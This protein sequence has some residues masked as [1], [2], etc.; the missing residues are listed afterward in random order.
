VWLVVQ[1]PDA[2]LITPVAWAAFGDV[3]I[4]LGTAPPGTALLLTLALLCGGALALLALA[5]ALAPGVRGFGG[6]FGW[7]LAAMAAVVLGVNSTGIIVPLTWAATALLAAGAVRASGASSRSEI[8]P[9]GIGFGLGASLLLLFGLLLSAPAR[10][11]GLGVG[12]PASLMIVLAGLMLT[13]G[14]PF[15]SAL[16]EA[17]E[18]PAPLGGLIY[19]V[20]FPLLALGTLVQLHVAPLLLDNAGAVPPLHGGVTPLLGAASLLACAAGALREHSLRRL[21]GWLVG[22]QAGLV[23]LA[24]GLLSGATADSA[25]ALLV[26]LALLVNLSLSTLGGALAV[27]VLERATGSDDFTQVQP[28]LDMRFAG[29]VWLLASISALGLPVSW[30]FWARLWLYET[31]VSQMAW[32]LP[33][34]LAASVL[35]FLAYVGPLAR[36]WWLGSGEHT[37]FGLG[38][39]RAANAPFLPVLLLMV[40]LLLSLGLAPRLVW[41]AGLDLPVEAI[42]LDVTAQVISVLVAV[43]GLVF[44]VLLL[45]RPSTRPPLKDEDMEPV[46]LAPDGLARSLN[47]LAAVGRPERVLSGIWRGLVFAGEM[48]LAAMVLFERRYYLVGVLLALISLILVMSQ[49]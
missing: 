2:A 45:R 37:P 40:V 38:A 33:F 23:V 44:V 27:A 29:V 3:T 15:R 43:L 20:L 42:S 4:F 6:V 10:A 26:V 14:A 11:A 32:A 16:G 39:L 7:S 31:A 25:L 19:G 5:L 9:Y 41:L 46:V 30:G 48:V 22:A 21:L 47:W 34:V 12:I 17:L 36:F 8:P 1:P 28:G 18:A 24:L 49:G 35:M 13:G